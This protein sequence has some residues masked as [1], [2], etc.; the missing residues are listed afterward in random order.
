MKKVINGSLYNTETAQCLGY[1]E[2]AGSNQRD[3][4]YYCETLYRTKSG[5]YF[6]HGEGHGN[7][8]YGEWHGNSGGWGEQIRPY[9]P[10]EAR[11]WAEE[12]LTADEYAKAFG[13]PEEASDAKVPLN[14]SVSPEV[15]AILQRLKEQTGKSISQLIEEKFIE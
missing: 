2:P 1:V 9:T 4:N 6:L 11:E 7:S 14:I 8:R 15:K 12:N 5:K 10:D 3:F 13:E